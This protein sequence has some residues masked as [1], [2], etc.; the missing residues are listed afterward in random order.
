MR[1][2]RWLLVLLVLLTGAWYAWAPRRAWDNFLEAIVDGREHDLQETIEFP[3]LRGNLKRDLRVAVQGRMKGD[4]PLVSGLAGALIDPIVDLTMTPQGLERLVT[5]FGTR[6]PRP[7][8][9][10]SLAAGTE[11]AFRYRGPSRVDVRVNARGGDPED[12]GIFTFQRFGLSWR[13]VR[14]WSE[15]LAGL[16]AVT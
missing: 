5:G 9:A 12:A 3:I 2:L 6:T 8:E 10:D 1:R 7:G 14:I 16:E 15:R 13:L 11:T 4:A